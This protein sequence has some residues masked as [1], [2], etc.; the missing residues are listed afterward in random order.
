MLLADTDTDSLAAAAALD[1]PVHHGGVLTEHALSDLDL[2]GIGR[3]LTATANAEAAA[4]AAGALLV[5]L[6]PG[7]G[8]RDPDPARRRAA[9]SSWRRRCTRG[10][11]RPAAWASS[12]SPSN[13]S[14][15]RCCEP[16]P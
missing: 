4:L 11:S 13:L 6:R 14:A 3:L 2:H 12:P 7:R 10:G 9:T 8:L 1:L 16:T 5:D 15:V